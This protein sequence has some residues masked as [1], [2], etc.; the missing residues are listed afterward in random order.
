MTRVKRGSVARK[1]H[2]KSLKTA[3][4]FVGAGSKLFR[5]ANQQGIK[6][7]SYAYSDRKNRK[8]EFRRLWVT[9]I[10]AAAKKNGISYSTM[11]HYLYKN[12]V[13]L[14]RKTLGQVATLDAKCFSALAQAICTQ[15]S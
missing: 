3:S 11:I 13:C 14:N 5:T 4:G 8:R 10:N 6:A 15:I 9:R 2:E 12:Q 7:L 1:R